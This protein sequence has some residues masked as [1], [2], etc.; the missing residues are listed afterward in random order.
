MAI[1][2]SVCK[3]GEKSANNFNDLFRKCPTHYSVHYNNLID[4][5]YIIII[6]FI[7]RFY[8]ITLSIFERNVFDILV[9]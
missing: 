7:K 2:V 8:F 5:H 6:I 3:T 4:K 1:I 9:A